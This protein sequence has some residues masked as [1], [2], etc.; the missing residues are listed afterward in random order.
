MAIK[1][2][3]GQAEHHAALDTRPLDDTQAVMYVVRGVVVM[4]C[5]Y[6]VVSVYLIVFII[7]YDLFIFYLLVVCCFFKFVII[8]FLFRLL[9]LILDAS[10]LTDRT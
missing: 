8:I 3:L 9:L 10:D 7:I 6:L 4:V 2:H 1:A 5:G